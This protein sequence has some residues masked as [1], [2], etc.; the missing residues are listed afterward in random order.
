V[1]CLDEMGP[2]AA[3]S[4]PGS[5]IIRP[6]PHGAQRVRATQEVDDGRR[7][8]GYVLG[9]FQPAT[10]SAFTVPYAGRTTARWVDFLE[11]V[12]GWVAPAA[13]RVYAILDNLSTHRAAAVLRWSLAHPRWAFGFQPTYAASLNLIEPWWKILRS[14]ALK[15][16]RFETWQEICAAVAVATRY[17]NAHRHPFGWRRRRRHRPTRRP[18]IGCLPGIP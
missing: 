7:G 17:W 1:I 12:D 13:T 15:G 8:K 5:R 11:R 9:A 4:H 14:L 2:E 6:D 18:G 10:G 3:K 16:R